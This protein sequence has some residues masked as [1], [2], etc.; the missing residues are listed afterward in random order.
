MNPNAFTSLKL[1][2]ALRQAIG[3][4]NFTEMTG[5]QAACIPMIQLGRD[6]IVQSKTGSGKTAAFI[7][8]ALDKINL[9]R[10]IPQV[11]I[12]C[13][14]RELCDQVSKECL[15]FSKYILN[16]RSMA[17][18][19]GQPSV[20]QINA[21]KAGVHLIV[22]TPGRTLEFL[23]NGHIDVT[24][25]K[26]LILD[27]ADRL[28]EVGFFEEMNS[29]IQRLHTDRQTLFFSATFPLSM[30][31]FSQ[32]YQKNV[33]RLTV[34]DVDQGPSKIEQFIYPAEKSEKLETLK[35][36]L[37]KHPSE[38][39]LIFCR[40][41]VAVNEIGQM[42]VDAQIKSR[43]LHADLKQTERDLAHQMFRDGKLQ[44]LVATDV[45]ARGL[46]IDRLQLVINFDLPA[47]TDIYIH[48]IGRTGRAGR[49]GI[50][51]NI[52]TEYEVP[53]VADIEAAIGFKMIRQNL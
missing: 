3:D 16:F 39:T 43:I 30:E 42:L 7:I 50:A 46:D 26:T 21:L 25:I 51:V 18:I 15:K 52:A 33:E 11:L 41:K 45:A 10:A 35:K 32:R 4:L 17:L 47:S 40:T 2:S 14:T 23:N 53:L 38:C 34:Q 19:G 5:V 28:L 29:I 13:P 49:Y 22:G 31:E 20:P 1:S 12:L 6:L 44:V 24:Q 36:I 9:D 27:E 37:K 8:P 48:R